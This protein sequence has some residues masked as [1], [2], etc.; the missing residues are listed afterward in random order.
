MAIVIEGYPHLDVTDRSQSNFV[1]FIS[2][3]DS[4]VLKHHHG[5]SEPPSLGRVLID[6][7]IVS[8]ENAGFNGRIGLHASGNGGQ[9]L[10]EFYVKRGLIRLAETAHLPIS[11]R[12]RNDG[13]FFYATA[14]VAKNLARALDPDR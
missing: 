11:V 14:N 1:W 12:R 10:L 4:D 3:A 7:A 6:C 13:R 5:V 9:R 8:S 2:A